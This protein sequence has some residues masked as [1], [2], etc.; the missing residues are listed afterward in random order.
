VTTIHL[1]TSW[2]TS[3]PLTCS[4]SNDGVIQLGPLSSGAMFEVIEISDACLVHLLVRQ[5]PIPSDCLI[6]G[7]SQPTTP[8][9][10]QIQSAVFPQRTGQMFIFSWKR[11]FDDVR[12]TWLLCNVVKQW[13]Y[14]YNFLVNWHV[15]MNC[16]R[17]CENLL[18]FV[19]A[20]PKIL[21][22]PFFSEHGEYVMLHKW[23][24]LKCVKTVWP[25]KAH[26]FNDLLH[27]EKKTIFSGFSAHFP[28]GHQ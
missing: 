11:H 3:T 25:D 20:M 16:A 10:I 28:A 26:K 5:S 27:S 13:W 17:N 12:L 2:K 22:V 15:N 6:L 9:G 21:L 1:H 7:P 4:W 14:F 18:N 19:K 8:N 23:P 24:D